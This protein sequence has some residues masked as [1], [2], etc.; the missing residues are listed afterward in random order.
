VKRPLCETEIEDVTEGREKLHIEFIMCTV[1]RILYYYSGWIKEDVLGWTCRVWYGKRQD[2]YTVLVRK[3]EDSL[4]LVKPRRSCVENIEV[5]K[6][7][8]SRKY[9]E[10]CRGGA[11]F[12]S[13]LSFSVPYANSVPWPSVL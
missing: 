2:P 7:S 6:V 8:S 1:Y 9:S 13:S 4:P 3:F 10:L 12:K 11:P 5:E